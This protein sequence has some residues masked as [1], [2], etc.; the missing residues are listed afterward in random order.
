MRQKKVWK[1]P[2]Q[3]V[4]LRPQGAMTAGCFCGTWRKPSML[5]PNLWSW[6]ESTCPTSSA[7]P[8]IAPTKGSSL[9]VRATWTTSAPCFFC[10][11]A[12]F[13]DAVLEQCR[14][15][16]DGVKSKHF[17]FQTSGIILQYVDI[18]AVWEKTSLLYN[19]FTSD[20]KMADM[21]VKLSPEQV[22]LH[23][24]AVN[25]ERFRVEVSPSQ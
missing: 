19:A 7:W 12:A 4:L 20:T 17:E 21:F 8:L 15:K 14:S 3:S 16:S 24:Q 22:L 1:Q 10:S 6:R 18:Q 13:S 5:G 23:C 11:K 2:L 9:A 25:I